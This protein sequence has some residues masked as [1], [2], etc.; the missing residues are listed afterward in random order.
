MIL[1]RIFVTLLC[2]SAFVS[3]DSPT[4]ESLLREAGVEPRDVGIQPT[5]L[6]LMLGNRPRSEFSNLIL[7]QPL[8]ADGLARMLG[9]NLAGAAQG[10]LP[11]LLLQLSYFN[12]QRLFRGLVGDPTDK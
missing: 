11:Q 12:S 9:T 6:A 2:M 10:S 1:L 7:T 5:D 8:R 4:I 3:A